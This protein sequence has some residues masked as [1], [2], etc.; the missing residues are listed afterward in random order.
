MVENKKKGGRP[1][2]GTKVSKAKKTT[3]KTS[4]TNTKVKGPPKKRGRKPKG[5]K[6]MT[7][8]VDSNVN[9]VLKRPNIILHLKCSSKE[10]VLKNNNNDPEFMDIENLQASSL[11]NEIKNKDEENIE[12]KDVWEKIK[13]L[14]KQLHNNDISGKKSDCFWCTYALDNPPI[15]K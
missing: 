15:P 2:K 14:R 3:K 1:K 7:T 13:I 12:Q 5:G 4:K 8:I 11:F 6:I 10:F 9:K